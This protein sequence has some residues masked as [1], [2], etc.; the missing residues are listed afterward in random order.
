MKLKAWSPLGRYCF[1]TDSSYRTISRDS[2][3]FIPEFRGS[4]PYPAIRMVVSNQFGGQSMLYNVYLED[5][6]YGIK[7]YYGRNL[8]SIEQGKFIADLKLIELGYEIEEPFFLKD[9]D[10]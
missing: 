7:T 10:V 8:E 6:E 1:D 5:S 3:C 2:E 9:N 4:R